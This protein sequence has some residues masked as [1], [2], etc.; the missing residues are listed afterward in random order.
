MMRRMPHVFALLAALD[1]GL[2]AAQPSSQRDSAG[3]RIIE[4]PQRRLALLPEWRIDGPKVRI[5]ETMSDP[6]YEFHLGSSPWRFSER[7]RYERRYSCGREGAGRRAGPVS[8]CARR[9]SGAVTVVRGVSVSSVARPP[10][11]R[12]TGVGPALESL[13]RDDGGVDRLRFT[14]GSHRARQ[15]ARP[16]RC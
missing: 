7:A 16:L 1:A 12:W 4:V 13:G 15:D 11:C 2:V 14:R 10:R 8:S 3:I 6:P 9:G 5:G